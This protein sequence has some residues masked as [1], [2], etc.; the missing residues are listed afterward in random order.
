VPVRDPARYRT[1]PWQA[2]MDCSAAESVLD[3]RP[4]Y[5]WSERL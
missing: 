5:R 4:R 2:L 1:D 3:W